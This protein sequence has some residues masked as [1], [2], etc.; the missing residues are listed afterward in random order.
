MIAEIVARNVKGGGS[1]ETENVKGKAFSVSFKEMKE[2][3]S[4]VSTKVPSTHGDGEEENSP[5]P[6][7]HLS[8]FKQFST[9]HF[10]MDRDAIDL[11]RFYDMTN[12]KK[13][14][15]GG[16]AAVYK[17]KDLKSHEEV[18]IKKIS[19]RNMP[20]QE[21]LALKSE[22]AIMKELDHP[23][24]L[25]IYEVFEDDNTFF[26]ILELCE[27][28]EL[29]DRLLANGT[30][31]EKV[32]A[33]YIFQIV[34]ALKYAQSKG[35][36]H[37][38][39]K[40]ENFLFKSKEGESSLKIADWGFARHFTEGTPMRSQKGTPYYV[41]PQ[42]LEGKYTEKCDMWSTGVIAY[43]LLSGC[44]PFNANT[45]EGIFAKILRGTFEFFSPEWDAISQQAKDFIRK[46][47]QYDPKRRFSADQ[48]LEHPWLQKALEETHNHNHDIFHDSKLSERVMEG[49]R[50]FKK[51]N[52][53]KKAALSVIAK[54]LGERDVE[55]MKAVFEEVDSDGSGTLSF[56]EIRKGLQ[57]VGMEELPDD[58][59]DLLNQVDAD[60][61]GQIDYSEFLAASME[62]KAYA[63]EEACWS[64]FRVFDLNGD[65]RITK[66]ELQKVLESGSLQGDEA[67]K[68]L[69]SEVDT[70]G[71]GTIDFQE[72]VAMMRSS[73]S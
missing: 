59:D 63:S 69:M 1:H 64:A 18:A 38:D 29:F 3:E 42:V 4:G 33:Q 26:L 6:I 43:M 9:D 14:G 20:R 10:V 37:R 28:G 22:I 27:G 60:G 32:A 65:G 15:E 2:K 11:P 52:L 21:L 8:S 71:D 5:P 13:I 31:S 51:Q 35:V 39:L 44:P 66:E 73:D 61:S 50:S 72:F 49:L 36:V 17:T 56:E 48:A 16:Y 53:M 19:K 41:A 23:N 34:S 68:R 55:R 57:A 12:A 7:P 24:I 25:R 47:I 58:L 67:V 46:L 30:F 70:D 40:M 45:D 62:R 54:H